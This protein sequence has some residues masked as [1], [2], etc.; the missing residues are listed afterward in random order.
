[1]GIKKFNFTF[2]FPNG[3]RIGYSVRAKHYLSAFK[4]VRRF[5]IFDWLMDHCKWMKITPEEIINEQRK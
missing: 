2:E 3:K 4:K 5:K 1:M